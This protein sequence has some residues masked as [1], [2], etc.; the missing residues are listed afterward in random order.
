MTVG[1][2]YSLQH[3]GTRTDV[4][5][6][7]LAVSFGAI[8]VAFGNSP[9]MAVWEVARF[10][11]ADRPDRDA[12]YARAF[13]LLNVGLCVAGTAIAM[14]VGDYLAIAAVPAYAPV[15]VLV[16]FTIIAYVFQSWAMI[17]DTGT[18]LAGK[19]SLIAWSN[20][21]AAAVAVIG[22]LTLVPAWGRY[23]AAL[24]LLVAFGLRFLLVYRGSQRLLP[25]RYR[26]KPI[27]HLSI[28]SVIWVLVCGVVGSSD[29]SVN[30]L[31]WPN[32]RTLALHV[33]VYLGFLVWLWRAN[34]LT[35]EERQHARR[36]ATHLYRRI[37][38]SGQS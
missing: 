19:T 5:L 7:A 4:G 26:W 11:L 28:G 18:L 2:R 20:W 35:E 6:F 22:Y 12:L 10:R 13:L 34:I 15:A 1:W 9:F 38:P 27:L 25:I 16:P 33:L 8:V 31:R 36:A 17:L 3:F 21:F 32:I 24:T 29:E 37:V 14:F 30:G 23:G